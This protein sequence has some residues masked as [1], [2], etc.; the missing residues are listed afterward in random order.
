MA[1]TSIMPRA[2]WTAGTAF[3]S[4]ATAGT[5]AAIMAST[6][7]TA[8][9]AVWTAAA[10]AIASTALRALK[11]CPGIAA[12]DA[13]GIAREIFARSWSAAD[14][15]GAGF[16]GQKDDVVFDDGGASGALSCVRFDHFGFG[17]LVFRALMLSMFVLGVF[18]MIVHDV[19]GIA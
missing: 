11:A 17:V 10:T 2:T 4:R 12:A 16:A 5:A 13:S 1:V 14:A 6:I 15:R 18:P 3:E 19:C 8:S 7:G 9:A